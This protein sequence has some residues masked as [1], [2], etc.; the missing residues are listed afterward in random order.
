MAVEVRVE[1][2]RNAYITETGRGI[3]IVDDPNDAS[4]IQS[5]IE[6]G[7]FYRFV[8]TNQEYNNPEW[9]WTRVDQEA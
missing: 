2:V 3:V 4:E 7:K 9:E 5:A 8:L 1:F 6:A